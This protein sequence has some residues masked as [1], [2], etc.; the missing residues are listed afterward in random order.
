MNDIELF[1][2]LVTTKDN[3][4]TT[5]SRKIA[6]LFGKR[7]ADVLR[8]IDR[9]LERRPDLSQYSVEM[10]D[11]S[12]PNGRSLRFYEI[13]GE[14]TSMINAKFSIG[15]KAGNIECDYLDRIQD[16]FPHKQIRQMAVCDGRYRVDCYIPSLS[17]V[18]EIYEKEHSQKR[19]YDIERQ[20][21]IEKWIAEKKAKS[22]GVSVSTA[23]SWTG[24]VVIN[25]GKF[26]FGVRDILNFVHEE[27]MGM[28]PVFDESRWNDCDMYWY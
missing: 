23:M 17:V 1:R 11:N 19:D 27:F 5:T 6:D 16:I 13:H 12:G 22:E 7:H 10:F 4:V 9:S 2:Q 28:H 18:V 3:Q 26:G 8:A 24:F 14:L 21:N 15:A 25:E 20:R